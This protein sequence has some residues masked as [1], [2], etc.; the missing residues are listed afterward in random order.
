MTE[1]VNV[2][3]SEQVPLRPAIQLHQIKFEG[4]LEEM[5]REDSLAK[6]F[7]SSDDGSSGDKRLRTERHLEG[8]LMGKGG[9]CLAHRFKIDR[10]FY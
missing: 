6:R 9:G 4:Y 5:E 7:Q 3:Q 10:L 2:I 1:C 8:V